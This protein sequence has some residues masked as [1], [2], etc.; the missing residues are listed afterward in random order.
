MFGRTI[1][2]VKTYNGHRMDL[3]R[4]K[5]KTGELVHQHSSEF[6][7][8][9]SGDV[10]VYTFFR[11]GGTA[12]DGNSYVYSVDEYSFWE[13]PGLLSGTNYRNYV[14][15]PEAFHWKRVKN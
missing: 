8:S 5:I 2:S 15:E 7:L 13:V 11:V 3:Q 1:R 4:Y 10:R 9:K 12:K 6:R 14:Q